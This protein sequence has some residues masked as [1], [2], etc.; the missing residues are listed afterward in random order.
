MRILSCFTAAAALGGTLVLAQAGWASPLMGS[1]SS[2]SS[3]SPAGNG[4]IVKVHGWHCSKKKGWYKGNNV[5]HRHPRAC[6]E[7]RNYDD[8]YYYRD[9]YLKP[10]RPPNLYINPEIRLRFGNQGDHH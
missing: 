9:D 10:G 2:A 1:L 7:A 6:D 8:D 3:M 5:W 4:T